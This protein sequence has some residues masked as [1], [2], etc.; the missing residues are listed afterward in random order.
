MQTKRQPNWWRQTAAVANI[1]SRWHQEL[2]K[3]LKIVRLAGS[4]V[5][6]WT[7]LFLTQSS[8]D[9]HRQHFYHYFFSFFWCCERSF[10]ECF[11]YQDCV[12]KNRNIWTCARKGRSSGTWRQVECPVSSGT[13]LFPAKREKSQRAAK[14]D[15]VCLCGSITSLLSKLLDDGGAMIIFPPYQVVAGAKFSSSSLFCKDF[16]L[17][18]AIYLLLLLLLVLF[19]Q[20]DLPISKWFEKPVKESKQRAPTSITILYSMTPVSVCLVCLCV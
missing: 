16:S 9:Y 18:R 2:W 13:V 10:T 7:H 4:I 12:F 8:S 17:L 3:K 1:W 6:H 19:V 5:I 14:P 20:L 15:T 11:L